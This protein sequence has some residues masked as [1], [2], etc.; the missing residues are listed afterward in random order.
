MNKATKNRLLRLLLVVS[1][2]V[3]G[4]LFILIYPYFTGE[5]M[6][7]RKRYETYCG[8]CH[9]KEGQGFRDLYP[10]L[11]GSDYLSKHETE[12]PCLIRHGLSGTITVNGKTFDQPMPELPF[13][14]PSQ[15]ADILNFVNHSWGNHGRDWGE[16]DVNI[17]L[18]KCPGQARRM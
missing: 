4:L 10:P 2:P 9:G 8:N 11:A 17:V 16:K 1:I 6:T 14:N 7:D 18:G 15:I 3:S 13:L 12:L 5:K